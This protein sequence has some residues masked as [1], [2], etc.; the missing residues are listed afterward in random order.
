[1]GFCELF[2]PDWSQTAILQISAIQVARITGVS[3]LYS[4]KIIINK[5]GKMKKYKKE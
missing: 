4:A 3:H 1:M 5:G 2:C